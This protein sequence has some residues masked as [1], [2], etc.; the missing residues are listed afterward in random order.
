[1]NQ[2]KKEIEDADNEDRDNEEE[3]ENYYFYRRSISDVNLLLI[4]KLYT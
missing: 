2:L 1:M 4:K 3:W